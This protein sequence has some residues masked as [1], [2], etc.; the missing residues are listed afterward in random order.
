MG[1]ENYVTPILNYL[2]S[3]YGKEYFQM[4]KIMARDSRINNI[5][6]KS[7][8][9]I[10]PTNHDYC[11]ILDDREDVWAEVDPLIKIIPYFF[12]P[13]SPHQK[14]SKVREDCFLEL[15]GIIML[16]VW[17]VFFK[18]IQQGNQLSVGVSS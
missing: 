15:A 14:V 7:I 8:N 10:F 18:G 12:F 17:Q 5:D 4:S 9:K 16:Y 6:F 2:N 11:I 1:T 13:Q 3:E